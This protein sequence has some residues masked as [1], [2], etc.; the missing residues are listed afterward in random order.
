VE[1]QEWLL[2]LTSSIFLQVVSNGGYRK[3]YYPDKYISTAQIAPLSTD[4]PSIKRAFIPT[5]FPKIG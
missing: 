4:E 5:K 1:P 3:F 2:A